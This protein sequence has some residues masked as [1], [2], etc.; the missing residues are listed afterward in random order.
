MRFTLKFIMLIFLPLNLFA[1]PEPVKDL[2]LNRYQGLWHQLAA[3]PADFQDRCSGNTTA[4]Y[5]LLPDGL[6]QVINSCDL[7]DGNER[8]VSEARARINDDFGLNSTLEVTFVSFLGCWVWPFA[9]DYWV[10]YISDDY[11]RVIVGHPDYEYGWILSKE[12]ALTMKEYRELDVELKSQGYD[13]CDFII[14]PTPAQTV[15][16]EISLCEWVK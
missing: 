7:V 1:A 11:K 4:E 13:T 2:D 6:I 3:I 5:K 15:Y 12:P 9:G 16:S 8:S 14:S 10:T